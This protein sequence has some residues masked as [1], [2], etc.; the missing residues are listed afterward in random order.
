M[1]KSLKWN[2]FVVSMAEIMNLV[3]VDEYQLFFFDGQW[4]R[5]ST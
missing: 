3:G 2:R 1:K 5:K 4:P